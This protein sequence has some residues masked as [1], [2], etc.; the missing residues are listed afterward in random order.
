VF[1]IGDRVIYANR[2]KAYSIGKNNPLVGTEHFCEGTVY[3]LHTP[4]S[5]DSFYCKVTWDNGRNNSYKIVDLELVER[6][7]PD[8]EV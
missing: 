3:S 7:I 1:Q 6:K 5:P 8:W 4:H 2:N